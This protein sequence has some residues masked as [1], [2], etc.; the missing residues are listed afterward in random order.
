MNEIS[1]TCAIC[2]GV[3]GR[4]LL[5]IRQPDR[6]ETHVGI[7]KEGYARSWVECGSCGAASNVQIP[8][9]RARLEALASGYYEVDFAN[10]SIAE[11][12]ARVMALPPERSDN[13]Q[14]VTRI[15]AFM[16]DWLP[17]TLSE[18]RALDIGAGTGVFLA[19]FLDEAHGRGWCA[20]A[21]EPDPVAAAHLRGLGCFSVTEALF[22]T[23]LGLKDFNLVTLNK[24]VEH[25]RE[26][27]R[28][29]EEAASALSPSFGVLYVEVP[30]KL[31]VYH[32]PTSDNILGALHCHLYHPASLGVLIDRAGLVTLK[33]ERLFEPS[34]KI[35]VVAFAT[36]PSAA[37]RLAT[38]GASQ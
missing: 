2:N 34:G 12:F 11:K 35:S 6:F 32:R 8:E 21:V 15:K 33:I 26:P 13:A 27:I 28:L 5:Q 38:P 14:R 30:D 24:V 16:N 17:N 31:T 36:L 18:A 22:S 20:A 25:V 7:E 3:L 10:S 1:K 4:E 23:D 9:H 19:R 37:A 29:I